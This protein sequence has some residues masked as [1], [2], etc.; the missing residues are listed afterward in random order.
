M[1]ELAYSEEVT[2]AKANEQPIVALESTII[3]HGM[4]FP[5]NMET[6]LRVEE[7]V[8]NNGAVPATLAIIDGVP[9]IGLSHKEIE[10]LAKA[11]PSVTKVS[12]RDFPVVL[13]QK[14]HGATTVA[15][16]MILAEKAGIQIFATGGIGGVHRNGENTLDISA[17]LQELANTSVAVISAGVKSILD[18][19]LT[20]EYLETM[21]VP[22]WGYQT[23]ELPAF[24]TRDSGFKLDRRVDDV[25]ELA[26][27]L[28]TKW[29]FGLRGGVLI[30]NPVPEVA[31]IPKKE[32]N[33]FIEEALA[34]AHKKGV[35]GKSI[36]PFLLA[37]IDELTQGSSLN[38]NIEL[39]LNNAKL[40]ANLAVSFNNT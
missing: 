24:F 17:D 25:D 4:P 28:K 12:R 11:G 2:A 40:A 15:G 39:I 33:I 22:V 6:A 20:L 23:E 13:T 19:G 21:G 32:I 26:Q 9:K 27:L 34:Q 36:T 8:R 38:T 18:L 14:L 5:R 10:I 35:T 1:I 7:I 29:S 30:G 31:S 37:K 3:S 16:T